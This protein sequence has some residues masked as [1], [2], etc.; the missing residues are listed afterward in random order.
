[1][2]VV[3]SR[4]GIPWHPYPAWDDRREWRLCLRVEGY[5]TLWLSCEEVS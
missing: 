1:M 4:P 2:T 3:R 5:A